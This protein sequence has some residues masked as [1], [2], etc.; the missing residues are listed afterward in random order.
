M[1]N[2]FTK[3][4]QDPDEQREYRYGLRTI[5]ELFDIGPTVAITVL[6][7]ALLIILGGVVAFIRS[8]PP[9]KINFSA[10]PEDSIFKKQRF[11]TPKHLR[12]TASLSTF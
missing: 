8:A 3:N 7:I 5:M 12:R 1:K 9:T 2:V 11:A 4:P 10:G 6:S